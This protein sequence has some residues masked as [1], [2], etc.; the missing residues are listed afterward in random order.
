[1]KRNSKTF[2]S[3]ARAEAFAKAHKGAEIWTRLDA[4]KQR[5]YA[6]RW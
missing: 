1:M 6:V 2:L 3:K 4:F 5:E